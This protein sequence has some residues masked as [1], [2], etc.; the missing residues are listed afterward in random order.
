M[1]IAAYWWTPLRPLSTVIGE[2]IRHGRAWTRLMVENRRASNFGDAINPLVIRE[3][4][5]TDVE[6][7]PLG[8]EDLVCIGS[9]L[10]AY[11]RAH[12]VGQVFGSGSRSGELAPDDL[13]K[14]KVEGVR[15]HLTATSL[16]L[17]THAV[18]GDPGLAIRGMVSTVPKG[19]RGP[20]VY[21]PHFSDFSG[22]RRQIALAISNA[23]YGILLPNSP[24]MEI[25]G[26]IAKADHVLTTSLHAI[27]F[28]DA[29]EVPVARLQFPVTR[30]AEPSFKYDDYRSIFAVECPL[31]EIASIVGTSLQAEVRSRMDS[32]AAQISTRIDDVV[33]RIYSR[34]GTI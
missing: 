10:E 11:V 23:G 8:R 26:A 15:G 25:A 6:W 16:G 30:R 3:L 14:R 4:F 31:V 1:T 21:I 22:D 7:A 5:A 9:V 2:S 34:A 19:K 27:V 29:L 20:P 13:D 17:D 18:I 24:P 33:G 28:A 32:A 12:G